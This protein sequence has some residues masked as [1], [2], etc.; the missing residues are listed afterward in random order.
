[1]KER[2]LQRLYLRAVGRLRLAAGV[3]QVT[4]VNGAV[5]DTA[6]MGTYT[7]KTEVKVL[8]TG[9]VLATGTYTL[10]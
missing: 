2:G 1:M 4:T 7:I 9:A 6:P 5:K 8:S 3:D 10:T